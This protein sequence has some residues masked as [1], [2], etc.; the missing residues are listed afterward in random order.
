MPFEQ[1]AR[2][3]GAILCVQTTAETARRLT[4][5]AGKC[6]EVAPTAE[7]DTPAPHES[8]DQQPLQRGVFSADGIMVSL[9]KKQWVEVRTV[10]IG[11][12]QEQRTAEGEREIHVGQLSYFSRLADALTFTM[13]AE[14]EMQRRKVAEAKEISAVMDGADWL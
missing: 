3:L 10:A 8:K 6:M 4:E 1:A 13:L 2:M 11:Q 12:P 14:V 7:A 5:Q 9:V